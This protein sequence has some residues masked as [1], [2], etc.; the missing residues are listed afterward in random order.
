M[1]VFEGLGLEHVYLVTS[2]FYMRRARAIAFL[3]FGRRGIVCMPVGMESGDK[4]ES[5][6]KVL[7]DGVR[8]HLLPLR[9]SRFAD[10][11]GSSQQ[12][13]SQ[14]EIDLI[15]GVH[16]CS[17]RCCSA[18]RGARALPHLVNSHNREGNA[19]KD[20]EQ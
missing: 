1:E 10:K 3:V 14:R 4:E 7:R 20:F 12:L 6:W 18:E 11:K 8:S 19:V 17:M 15:S 5:G 16:D 2:D 9:G 13:A